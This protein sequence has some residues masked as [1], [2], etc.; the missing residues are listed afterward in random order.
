MSEPLQSSL[1]LVRGHP[2]ETVL[3]REYA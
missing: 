3:F 1:H 2:A